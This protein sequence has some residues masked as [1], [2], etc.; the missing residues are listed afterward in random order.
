MPTLRRKL[1]AASKLQGWRL[2]HGYATVA[3]KKKSTRK[4]ATRRK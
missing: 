3:R 1:K 2:K 4:K